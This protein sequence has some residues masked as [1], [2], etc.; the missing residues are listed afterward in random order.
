VKEGLETLTI[1]ESFPFPQLP[2]AEY[3]LALLKKNKQTVAPG[4]TATLPLEKDCSRVLKKQLIKAQTLYNTCLSEMKRYQTCRVNHL[5]D[6]VA[7]T[8]DHWG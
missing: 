4:L 3:S 5:E 2:M 6:R 7:L 8:G 1:L